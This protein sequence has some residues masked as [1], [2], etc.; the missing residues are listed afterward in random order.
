MFKPFAAIGFEYHK[1]NPESA[2]ALGSEIRFSIPQFGDFFNDMVFYIKFHKA[3]YTPSSNTT[4]NQQ[5]VFRYCD[6]PGERLLKKVSFNVNGN[7]LDDYNSNVY[8]LHRQFSI[9]P[10]KRLAWNRLI[11]QEVPNLAYL[12]QH[13]QSRPSSRVKIDYCDGFQTPKAEHEQLILM[14]PL[15][16]WFNKDP[17]LAIPSV[18][19]PYGQRFITMTLAKSSELIEL[20]TPP[21]VADTSADTGS[22]PTL[23]IAECS[24]WINNIFVNPE[25]HDI[26][27][28]RIGFTLI[29]VH[30]M[31]T[32]RVKDDNKEVVYFD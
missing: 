7:P 17:R 27:I 15:L 19:I 16:F 8:N 3:V 11:G 18:S 21:S 5:D 30:R 24:L 1:V 6:Y 10:N 26:F 2:V 25:V 4:E 32:T 31:Q 20:V 12:D 23:T 14:I 22:L 13:T 29:R 28:K 9:S